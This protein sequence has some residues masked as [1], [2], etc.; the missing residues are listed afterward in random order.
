MVQEN[1][2]GVNKVTVGVHEN[3]VGVHENKVVV[4][5]NA[6]RNR[7]LYDKF[8]MSSKYIVTKLS[9]FQLLNTLN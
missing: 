7:N 6:Q 2:V 3:I 1:T 4:H 9:I 8:T 5:E